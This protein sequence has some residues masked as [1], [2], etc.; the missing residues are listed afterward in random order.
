MFVFF[1][2]Q[3]M[4]NPGVNILSTTSHISD[5]SLLEVGHMPL[6][7]ENQDEQVRENYYM[8]YLNYW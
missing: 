7:P 1:S 6:C 3:L 5:D 8:Y 2:N 4:L